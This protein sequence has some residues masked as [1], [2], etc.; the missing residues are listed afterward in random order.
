MFV[1]MHVTV[2]LSTRLLIAAGNALKS[3]LSWI[4]L[5][6]LL[7]MTIALIRLGR[8]EGRIALRIDQLSLATPV[9]GSV[10]RK[11]VVS[12]FSRTL[13]TLLRSGV[14]LLEALDAANDVIENAVYSRLTGDLSAALREGSSIAVALERSSLFEGLFLQLV[15][16]GEE[17]GTLDAMLLRIADYY[18]LDVETAVATLSSVVEPI[19]IIGLGALVGLI[20]GSILIPLYSTIGSIK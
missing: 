6:A 17:T 4:A 1:E 5:A 8:R 19:L 13:G 12:R 14:P 20:V 10:L 18:D 15:R 11:A 16:V 3:P 7:P 2:P 9:F